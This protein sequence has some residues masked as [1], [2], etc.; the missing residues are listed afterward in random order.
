[1]LRLFISYFLIYFF[2]LDLSVRLP[3]HNWM[4]ER[5]WAKCTQTLLNLC[6]FYNFNII[7]LPDYW[8]DSVLTAGSINFPSINNHPHHRLCIFPDRP[9]AFC[10]FL[11]SIILA[12]TDCTAGVSLN[13]STFKLSARELGQKNKPIIWPRGHLCTEKSNIRQVILTTQQ[14]SVVTSNSWAWSYIICTLNI[15][16]ELL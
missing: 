3:T 4:R 11:S 5:S 2:V 13:F 10:Y 15:S 6:T 14:Y 16:N 1:M 9:D 8:P 12:S 7:F